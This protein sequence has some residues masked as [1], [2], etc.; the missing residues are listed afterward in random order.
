MKKLSIIALVLFAF[1]SCTSTKEASTTEKKEET[2]QP[3]N[4]VTPE[5]SSRGYEVK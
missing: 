5:R 1:I 3:T 4:T 2:K